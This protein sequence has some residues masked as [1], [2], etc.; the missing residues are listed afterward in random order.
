M[1]PKIKNIILWIISGLLAFLFIGSAFVK[2]SGSAM[3]IKNANSFGLNQTAF[4]ILG[5]IE[6]IATLLF[7]YPRTGVLG[8]FLLIAYMG[9]AIA[10][11]LEHGQSYI[12]PVIFSMVLWIVTVLRF[13][14][15]TKRISGK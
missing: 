12:G 1:N 13:P 10:T 4:M 2:L 9:G 6:I 11:H 8:A 7:L 15:L 14:E 3:A 5:V